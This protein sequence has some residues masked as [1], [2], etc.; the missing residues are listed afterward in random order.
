[1]TT[2]RAGPSSP[3][4]SATVDRG[5]L[6]LRTGVRVALAVALVTGCASDGHCP[7]RALPE[8]DRRWLTEL[9]EPIILPDEK[10]LFLEL[11][12]PYQREQFREEF[13]Q[14]RELPGLPPPLGPG[15]RHRY[16]E[17]RELADREY[18][19]WRED[20]GRM[21]LRWGEPA[22]IEHQLRTGGP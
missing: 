14:R 9:V 12:E 8:E 3:R 17:L 7:L 16:E 18:D 13:W 5:S 4:S 6:R 10:R 2:R 11:T 19:G 20:A 22:A 1:M 15:Y 21:V